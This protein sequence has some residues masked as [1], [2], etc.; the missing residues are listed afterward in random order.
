L[1]LLRQLND[2]NRQKQQQQQQQQQQELEDQ[3]LP[4]LTS[5]LLHLLSPAFSSTAV[6]RQAC[7]IITACHAAA[8]LPSYVIRRLLKVT[9]NHTTLNLSSM[10]NVYV[11]CEVNLT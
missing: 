9:L 6:T 7:S 3:P 2:F 4:V 1:Q 11:V 5:I 10:P 8:G